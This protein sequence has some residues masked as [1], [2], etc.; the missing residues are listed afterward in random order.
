MK[1]IF[2]FLIFFLNLNIVSAGITSINFPYDNDVLSYSLRIPL[3]VTSSGSTGCVFYYDAGLGNSYNQSILCNGDSLVD[4]PLSS[5]QY[6]LSVSD[7]SGSTQTINIEISRPEGIIV[8]LVYFLSILILLGLLFIFILNLAKFAMM[9]FTVYNVAVSWTF[10]FA[11]M[12]AYLFSLEYSGVPFVISWLELIQNIGLWF[13]I[14]F[15]L[16]ALFVTIF[17]KSTKK[18]NTLTTEELTGGKLLQYG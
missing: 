17:Y 8:A 7:D 18:K 4:L 10:Y 2:L 3:N 16:I 5:G 6:N 15:P 13:F 1:K 9:D 11:L 14:V 12:I